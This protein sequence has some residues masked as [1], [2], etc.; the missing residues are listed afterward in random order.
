MSPQASL[1]TGSV[2]GVRVENVEDPLMGKIRSLGKVVDELAKG[3]ALSNFIR[4]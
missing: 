4:S 3:K 1:I 2:C